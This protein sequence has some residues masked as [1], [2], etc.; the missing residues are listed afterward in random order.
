MPSPAYGNH[1]E[2]YGYRSSSSQLFC[3]TPTGT[4]VGNVLVCTVLSSVNVTWDQSRAPSGFTFRFADSSRLGVYTRLVTGSEPTTGGGPNPV[5]AGITAPATGTYT[6]LVTRI[7]GSF[8]SDP[9]IGLGAGSGG[10]FPAFDMEADSQYLA[11][12]MVA[13]SLTVPAALSGFTSHGTFG[14]ADEAPQAYRISS[15]AF[16]SAG[17]TGTITQSDGLGTEYLAGFAIRS[18]AAPAASASATSTED[19]G[20]A[21]WALAMAEEDAGPCSSPAF[22]NVTRRQ[23]IGQ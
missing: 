11:I 13:G 22:W 21:F 17:S 19:D 3:Q 15:K 8:T 4:V 14:S 1:I 6:C 23:R 7:A 2:D 20:D 16:A 9:F 10:N 12:T 5:Y 18:V